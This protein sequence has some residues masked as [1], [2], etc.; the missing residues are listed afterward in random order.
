L[1][2][3]TVQAFLFLDLVDIEELE[4]YDEEEANREL[5]DKEAKKAKFKLLGPLGKAHNIVVHMRSSSGRAEQFKKLAG[6]MIL[7]DNRTRWNSWRNMLEVLL[8]E[9]AHVD[10]YCE[11]FEHEL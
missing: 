5:T 8:K 11:D 1:L 6:R 3:S 4:S 2:T 7:I 9:K 10:K